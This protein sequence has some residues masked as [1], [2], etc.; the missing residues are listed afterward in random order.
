MIVLE[1]DL[2]KDK[3]MKEKVETGRVYK[4][5]EKKNCSHS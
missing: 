1:A 4:A 3:G 5:G 2:I